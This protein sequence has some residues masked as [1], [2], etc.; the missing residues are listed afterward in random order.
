MASLCSCGCATEEYQLYV[1]GEEIENDIGKDLCS[2]LLGLGPTFQWQ[3]RANKFQLWYDRFAN[4]PEMGGIA[5][6]CTHPGGFVLFVN[7]I[8][9][10]SKEDI[11]TFWTGR[12][13]TIETLSKCVAIGALILLI[14]CIISV[15]AVSN[16]SQDLALQLFCI[17]ALGL[18]SVLMLVGLAYCCMARQLKSK[19]RH[20][21][22]THTSLE[23]IDDDPELEPNPEDALVSTKAA[24][25]Q[26]SMEEMQ[27][28]EDFEFLDQRKYRSLTNSTF[29]TL[30]SKP[31]AV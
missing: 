21:M 19:A 11:Q 23:E 1:N 22:E 10:K 15:V 16:G 7:G 17:V 14:G 31:V 6:A 30:S 4:D 3:H 25:R 26:E 24:E 18:A 29:N 5:G 13:N 20:L 2:P 8:E 27:I 9:A 28:T 12:A